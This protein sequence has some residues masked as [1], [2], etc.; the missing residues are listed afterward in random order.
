[1]REH[2]GELAISKIH[3]NWPITTDDIDGLK[4][5]LREIGTETDVDRAESEAGGF[6]LFVRALVG[7]DG[8]AA[9]E[10]LA[11]FLDQKRYNAE[12]IDWVGLIVEEL[13]ENGIV[14]PRRFLGLAV[15]RAFAVGAE[16]AVHGR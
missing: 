4:R 8:T 6:G 13:T 11:K 16:L 3:M 10:A 1:M 2:R 12:Q 7:L 9:R 14:E 15:Q 5:V